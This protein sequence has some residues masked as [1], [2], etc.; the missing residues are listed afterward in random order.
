[1]AIVLK[2]LP[3][4]GL[5]WLTGTAIS[6]LLMAGRLGAAMDSGEWPADR[7]MYVGNTGLGTDLLWLVGIAVLVGLYLRQRA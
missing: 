7:A 5:S 6:T 2:P 4:S 3:R 1:M